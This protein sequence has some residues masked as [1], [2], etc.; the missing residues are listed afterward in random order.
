LTIVEPLAEKKSVKLIGLSEPVGSIRTQPTRL[1]SVL[2]NLTANAVEH[3]RDGGTVE[4]TFEQLAEQIEIAVRDTGEGIAPEHLPHLFEPFYRVDRAREA[5][6]HMGLGLYLV[7]S[8]V[9]DMGGTC[10]VESTVGVGTTFR[11]RLPGVAVRSAKPMP[12]ETGRP[13][14][15]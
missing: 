15:V 3:N 9:R 12:A 13:L 1:R 4:V 6:E 2:I 8:H 14:R 7:H 10:T 5:S 11:V